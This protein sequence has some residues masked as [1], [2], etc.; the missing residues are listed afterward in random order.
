[1][2]PK[3]HLDLSIILRNIHSFPERQTFFQTCSEYGEFATSNSRQSIFAKTFDIEYY[4]EWCSRLFGEIFTRERMEEKIAHFNMKFGG[5]SPAIGKAVYTN[6]VRDPLSVLN[7][8]EGSESVEVFNL[9][10][11][12]SQPSDLQSIDE[13]DLPE[14]RAAK[15]R[16]RELIVE[17]SAE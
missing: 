10:G 13:T 8:Q 5:L 15:Q 7:V 16:I 17:W 12:I 4:V 2:R 3:N 6:F 14:V 1:M 11:L 9:P